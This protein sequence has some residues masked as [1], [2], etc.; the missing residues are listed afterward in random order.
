MLL[1]NWKVRPTAGKV[2]NQ[3]WFEVVDA[4]PAGGY[5]V[6][7]WDFAATDREIKGNDPDG[8]ASCKMKFIPDRTGGGTYYIM[9]ATWDQISPSATNKKLYTLATQD[10]RGVR[11]RW[12]EEFGASGKRDTAHLVKLLDGWITGGIS[13]WGDKVMRAKPLAVQAQAGN[14]KVKRGPWNRRWLG[15]MHGFPDTPHKDE[16][17]A[18]SGAYEAIRR[19]DGY[20]PPGS[21]S[22]SIF[23]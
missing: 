14:V 17:D 2:F 11:V 4:V 21:S 5:T 23:G 10:G 6:R 22:S 20:E 9:D 1:G 12:E 16:V 15:Q 13:P 19:G 8:S 18:A 3:D 7:Y